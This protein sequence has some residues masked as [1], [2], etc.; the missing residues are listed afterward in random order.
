MRQ[1]DADA[2]KSAL[3]ETW[4]YNSLVAEI[5]EFIDKQ[6]TIQ[7]DEPRVMTLEEV[8][9]SSQKEPVRHGQ[10]KWLSSTY[11]RTPCEMRYMCDKCHHETI[12]HGQEPWEKYCPECGAKMDGDGDADRHG[13][14]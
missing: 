12:T 8:L 11:D 6:P 2:L 13:D 10:W 5:C 9:R 7:S 3:W 14:S 4:G 1:I